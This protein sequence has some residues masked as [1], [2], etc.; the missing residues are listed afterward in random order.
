MR[1]QIAATKCGYNSDVTKCPVEVIAPVLK[2][3]ET[4]KL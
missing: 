2:A 3:G 4:R 1:L